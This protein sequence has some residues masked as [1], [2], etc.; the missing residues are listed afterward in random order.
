MG[1][2]F[3]CPAAFAP[4]YDSSVSVRG[5]RANGRSFSGTFAACVLDEG[6]DEVFDDERGTSS[7]V[8]KVTVHI[9]KAGPRAWTFRDP[10]KVGDELTLVNTATGPPPDARASGFT[11]TF[12][13]TDVALLFGGDAYVLEARQ[14]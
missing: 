8:R 13:V 7:N 12:A 5:T 2:M 6:L 4:F 14:K 10:P 11:L 3:E 9:P 1:G